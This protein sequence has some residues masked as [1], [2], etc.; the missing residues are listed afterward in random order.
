MY[1]SAFILA[2]GLRNDRKRSNISESLKIYM[3]YLRCDLKCLHM[4]STLRKINF[5]LFKEKIVLMRV[6]KDKTLERYAFII[7]KKISKN[8]YD[9]NLLNPKRD[10]VE[11]TFFNI[12]QNGNLKNFFFA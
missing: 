3:Q 2:K 9:Q 7:K 1:D 5:L 4:C 8:T 11:T 6:I 10:F 12:K